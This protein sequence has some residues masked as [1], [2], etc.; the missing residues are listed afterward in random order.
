MSRPLASSQ[1]LRISSLTRLLRAAHEPGAAAFWTRSVSL[2]AAVCNDKGRA[3][4]GT[5]F[6]VAT[7]DAQLTCVGARCQRHKRK[8]QRRRRH[9]DHA[10]W[11]RHRRPLARFAPPG[12]SAARAHTAGRPPFTGRQRRTSRRAGARSARRELMGTSERSAGRT[13]RGAA[14]PTA[15]SDA[16]AARASRR[17]ARV[18]MGGRAGEA[19]VFPAEG[20][21]GFD[22]ARPYADP[23]AAFAQREHVVR[24]KLVKVETAKVRR[25]ER[26]AVPLLQGAANPSARSRS[27]CCVA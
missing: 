22:P 23:A 1:A 7:L 6:P 24:E 21:A 2:G 13:A 20:P 8:Q 17:R 10:Q 19:S 15:A 3:N 4:L 14:A 12:E 18:A 9:N 25:R 5:R 26:C 16:T 27:L 11:A